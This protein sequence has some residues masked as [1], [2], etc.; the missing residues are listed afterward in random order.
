MAVNKVV[1]AGETLIDT[2][3]ATAAAADMAEGTTAYGADGEKV[4]GTVKKALSGSSVGWPNLDASALS[5]S[6]ANGNIGLKYTVNQPSHSGLMYQNGA[7]VFMRTPAENY[8]DATPEDV[9]SGKTFTSVAGLLATGTATIG[10][11]SSILTTT[12]TPS[13]NSLTI[14]FTGLEDEPS[15]FSV[16]PTANITLAS[17]RYV[18]SVDYDGTAISGV[19]GYTSGSTWSQTA[20]NAYSTADFTYTYDSGTL[21][22]TSAMATTGG[23]FKSGT[24]YKLDYVTDAVVSSGGSSEGG[25]DTSDATATASDIANGKTAYIDGEKVTGTLQEATDGITIYATGESTLLSD[26][27]VTAF[28]LGAVYLPN[29]IGDN[30]KGAIIRPGAILA[31][32]NVPT[33]LFGDA[34]AADVAAG[35]TF[36][37]SAGLKVTGTASLGTTLPDGAI[38]VQMVT[39][40]QTSTRIAS[41]YSLS[42]TYGDALVIGNSI[43]LAFSGT[44]STLSSISDTTD[45]SVLSGKYIRSGSGTSATYY[46]IPSGATFTVG[47]STYSKTLTCDKAQAVTLQKVNL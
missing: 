27:G 2:S 41:G 15:L 42:I 38:A 21:T 29:N 25:I 45:F 22:I 46:Y 43:A 3:D 16:H 13:A 17:T 5:V 36:T 8:G 4:T 23:Y 37:S 32:R 35:K 12:A 47:G 19:C 26:P 44:T 18:V 40:A 1:Y 6:A 39:G 30:T 14:S 34:T 20:T 31:P 10:S 9:A 24:E 11:S 33:S 7:S 28:H